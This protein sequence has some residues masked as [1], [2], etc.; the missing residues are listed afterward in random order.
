[1]LW[2]QFHNQPPNARSPAATAG[3]AY[4][5]DIKV[6]EGD[7]CN[8]QWPIA[9]GAA[10]LIFADPNQVLGIN[11][12]SWFNDDPNRFANFTQTWIKHNVAY[13][14]PEHGIFIVMCHPKFTYL[15]QQALGKYL[16]FVD[17]IIWTFEFGTYRKSGW[18][19]AHL[20]FLIYAREPKPELNWQKICIESQRIRVG[21][22]RA[23]PVGRVPGTVWHFPRLTGN[24]GE[25]ISTSIAQ[26]PREIPERFLLAYTKPNDMVLDPFTGTG[27][28]PWTCKKLKINCCAIDVEEPAVRIARLRCSLM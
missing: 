21:D 20:K 12:Y 27:T 18:V 13:L 3:V 9:F 7:A 8:Y 19:P 28:V 22:T 15:Y 16:L 17:E 24:A 25:R 1:M 14:S 2:N 6:D 11:S 10:K 4:M 5:V 23:N 26:L